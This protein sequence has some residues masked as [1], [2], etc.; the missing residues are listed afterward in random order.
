VSVEVVS[1]PEA[2]ETINVVASTLW[3]A[4]QLD[5]AGERRG[6][7]LRIA[8]L[9]RENPGDH[10]SDLAIEIVCALATG[11]TDVENRG[12]V[13]TVLAQLGRPTDLGEL[14]ALAYAGNGPIASVTAPAEAWRQLFEEF[15]RSVPGLIDERAAEAA[16]GWSRIS[17][18]ERGAALARVRLWAGLPP[19]AAPLEV[20]PVSSE[21]DERKR[22]Y[23]ARKN[24]AA[25]LLAS[26]LGNAP[27]DSVADAFRAYRDA[28]EEVGGE[29][30]VSMEVDRHV[31]IR[32]FA[33]QLCD[34]SATSA[35]PLMSW[36]LEEC[37][38]RSRSCDHI[39]W[40]D[41]SAQ[42][43]RTLHL[44][45][46]GHL[47]PEEEG[48][49]RQESATVTACGKQV[50]L[51]WSANRSWQRAAPGE[52]LE[53]FEALVAYREKVGAHEAAGEEL[54][55]RF[56]DPDY[57]QARRIC[58]SCAAFHGLFL[59]CLGSGP[60]PSRWP[61]WRLA[62]IREQAISTLADRLGAG[63]TIG[64]V[65]RAQEFALEAWLEAE[66]AITARELKARGPGSLRRLFGE[67]ENRLPSQFQQWREACKPAGLEPNELLSQSLWE[68]VLTESFELF[69]RQ[70]GPSRNRRMFRDEI[71]KIV[72]ARI[73]GLP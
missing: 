44:F 34:L 10:V 4:D 65:K 41:Y 14:H 73:A 29:R 11:D 46:D 40:S 43:P 16:A 47:F 6:R 61:P 60:E 9:D 55:Y 22:M 2:G 39:V 59:E 31:R 63:R 51:R 27:A 62:E 21:P 42:H 12:T 67:R 70:D 38:L 5:H 15:A 8:Q 36:L 48:V 35:Q 28:R 17:T 1:G 25:G 3:S 66:V 68:R 30:S 13:E 33:D 45:P 53:H 58:A 54:P 32:E 56:F 50:L 19:I 72:E 18:A 26:R 7:D 57:Q 69:G 24:A 64:T 23:Q 49:S 20:S 37:S 71:R 52:W